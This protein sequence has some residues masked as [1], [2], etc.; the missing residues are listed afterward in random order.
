MPGFNHYPSCGCGWCTSY[1]RTAVVIWN[2]DQSNAQLVLKQHGADK[3][4]AACFINHNARCPRCNERV[5]YYQNQYGS[6]VFFDELAPLWTKHPCTDN[7]APS[8]A[9]RLGFRSRGARTEIAEA[10]RKAGATAPDEWWY[11]IVEHFHHDEDRTDLRVCFTQDPQPRMLTFR[12]CAPINEGEA[13]GLRGDEVSFF[14]LDAMEPRVA[15]VGKEIMIIPP[16]PAGNLSPVPWE[17][18]L[19]RRGDWNSFL[20]CW[21]EPPIAT[22]MQPEEVCNYHV[23]GMDVS[24]FGKRMLPS[25]RAAWDVGRRSLSSMAEYLNVIG[26]RTACGLVWNER[27]VYLLLKILFYR[28]S[29]RPSVKEQPAT[30]RAANAV[31]VATRPTSPMPKQIGRGRPHLPAGATPDLRRPRSERRLHAPREDIRGV[32]SATGSSTSDQSRGLDLDR[33]ADW[34]RVTVKKPR[35]EPSGASDR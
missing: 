16:Q 13:V 6:R 35:I 25:V 31:G 18:A 3:S 23:P 34:G 7:R 29:L 21:Q 15:K 1:G 4:R 12:G 30:L 27:R 11:G 28:P 24:A 10:L 32:Q 17:A 9:T 2:S 26:S 14:D 20:E 33:L 22:Q 8:G 19:L 5:F